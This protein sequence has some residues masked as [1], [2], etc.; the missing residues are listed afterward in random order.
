MSPEA[1]VTLLL[2]LAAGIIL[3]TE[4]LRADLVALLV[5]SVLGL[6]GIVGPDEIFSGFSGSVVITTLSITIISVALRQTGV[7]LLLS[8]VLDWFAKGNETRLV[9]ITILAAAVLS[10]FMVNIA[11]VGVLM[12]AVMALSRKWQIRPYKLL[13]PQAYGTTLGGMA[14]LLTTANIV[15]SASLLE[16]GYQPYSLL[17]FLPIGGMLVLAGT[18]YLMTI[19]RRLL[20]E[21]RTSEPEKATQRLGTRLATLYQLT[22]QLNVVRVLPDSPLANRSL[23]EGEWSTRTGLMVVGLV[24]NGTTH[25]A[26]R[27]TAYIHPGDRVVVHGEPDPERLAALKLVVDDSSGQFPQF[28]DETVVLAEVVVA[29]H[30]SIIGRTLRDL[31]FREKHSINVLAIWREGKPIH[32]GIADL[33]LE[34]GDALLVQ[35]RAGSVHALHH[36]EPDLILLEEDPDAV[37]NPGKTTITLLITLVTLIV[38]ATRLIPVAQAVFFGAVLLLLVRS[39]SMNEAYRGVE[40]RVVFLLAGMWPLSIAIRTTGLADQAVTTLMSLIGG[41]SP[42]L[43]ALVFLLTCL[44]VVQFM[45]GQIASLIL[46]PVAISAAEALGID[47]RGMGMAVALGCSLTFLTPFSHPSNL[48]VVSAGG[49]TVKDFLRVGAPLTLIVIALILAGLVVFWGF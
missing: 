23:A 46:A 35:G 2:I 27:G 28:I 6:T 19:G 32:S 34:F 30:A 21:E 48:L 40:W 17:D 12:P 1:I 3:I 18:L 10:L 39:L 13:L 8:R 33:P 7:S 31:R 42:L 37:L 24:S 43:V 16:A 25:L 29:P 41:A 5:L 26:P 15:V 44:A 14:T 49:Y 45:G 11:A 4:R 22:R 9:L 20:R 47:P 36:N 38:A